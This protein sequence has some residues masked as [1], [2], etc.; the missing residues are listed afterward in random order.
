MQ[1]SKSCQL[2]FSDFQKIFILVISA[3]QKYIFPIPSRSE[4]ALASVTTLGRGCGGRGS[5]GRDT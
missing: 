4:G 5:V 1:V 2:I 3:N